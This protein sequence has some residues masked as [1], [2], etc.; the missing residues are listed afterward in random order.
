MIQKDKVA[1]S[2]HIKKASDMTKRGR[3]SIANWLRQNAEYLENHGKEYATN[4]R[5]RYFYKG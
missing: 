2:I 3:K 1:A 5:A 4:F